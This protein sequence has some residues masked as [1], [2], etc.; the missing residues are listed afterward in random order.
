MDNRKMKLGQQKGCAFDDRVGIELSPNDLEAMITI[1][2]ERALDS[3]SYYQQGWNRDMVA[4]FE[5]A[6]ADWKAAREKKNKKPEK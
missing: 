4:L 6:Y 1:F 5:D 2:K 3:E